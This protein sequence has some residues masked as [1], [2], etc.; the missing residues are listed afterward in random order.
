MKKQLLLE[1]KNMKTIVIIT[2]LA[3]PL[4]PPAQGQ[5]RHDW[6]SLGKLQ[7]GDSIHLSLKTGPAKGAFQTWTPQQVTVEGVSGA[8]LWRR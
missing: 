4:L 5:D 6:L 7:P 8:C 2:L 1:H 3:T